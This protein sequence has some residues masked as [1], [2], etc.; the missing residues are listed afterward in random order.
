M[1][2][3]FV[4][5]Y[6]IISILIF[7][8][9][10]FS[11]DRVVDNA[12]LLSESDKERLQ[13]KITALSSMYNMDLIIVTERSIGNESPM[14]YAENFFT[15]NGYG[16]GDNR[17]GCLFLNVTGTRDIWA[18][19][20]GRAIRILNDTA[21]DKVL[22]D[23]AKNLKADN[24]YGAYH[25]FLANWEEFLILE[26][27]DRNYNII[28]KNNVYVII[29]IWVFA[30]GIALIVIMHWKR[31]MNTAIGQTHAAAYIV[32]GSLSFTEKKDRFLYSTVTKVKREKDSTSRSGSG[33]S[34]GG[35]GRRY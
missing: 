23:A 13:N 1:K 26:S 35:G 8:V 4:I 21:L 34:F 16:I 14:N 20:S 10:V 28:Q 5:L 19:T 12:G 30:F 17:D 22:D 29:G 6:L 33:R 24:H 27:K 32:P 25:S 2:T 9:P 3:K 7:A 18:T 11:Q 15:V 31:Q